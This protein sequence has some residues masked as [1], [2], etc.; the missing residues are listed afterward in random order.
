M[1]IK[2]K[3]LGN[4]NYTFDDIKKSYNDNTREYPVDLY[5]NKFN[6]PVGRLIIVSLVIPSLIGFYILF[7]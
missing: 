3:D 2:I 1:T 7:K 5:D 6:F 4:N